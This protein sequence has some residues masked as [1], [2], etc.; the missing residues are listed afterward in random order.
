MQ[1]LND[2]VGKDLAVMFPTLDWTT[3]SVGDPMGPGLKLGFDG[4][5]G[6][7]IILDPSIPLD[8]AIDRLGL[9]GKF[10]KVYSYNFV[11]LVHGDCFLTHTIMGLVHLLKVG[12]CLELKALSTYDLALDALKLL[13]EGRIISGQILEK[14][15][16]TAPR[17]AD[18]LVYQQTFMFPDRL[19]L[20]D[21]ELLKIPIKPQFQTPDD[22]RL[23]GTSD[24]KWL[25]GNAVNRIKESLEE[26][27]PSCIVCGRLATKMDANRAFFSRYCKNH[28][29][30]AREEC[31]RRLVEAYSF[32]MKFTKR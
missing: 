16:F 19:R 27:W 32:V 12:G 13:G 14:Y 23:D 25:A 6:C 21:A 15:C 17:D 24:D 31:D 18:G 4:F 7:D 8:M 2:V 9:R 11:G 28:Y 5:E 10:D 3:C 30:Q 26:D 22:L 20:A 29:H 1:Q